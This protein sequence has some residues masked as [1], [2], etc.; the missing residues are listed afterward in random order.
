MLWNET[1]RENMPSA[2]CPGPAGR[3]NELLDLST[4]R[5]YCQTKKA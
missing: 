5:T 3:L 1:D 4:S 2:V